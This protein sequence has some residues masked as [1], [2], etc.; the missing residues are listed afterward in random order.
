MERLPSR[1]APGLSAPTYGINCAPFLALCVL[2]FIASDDCGELASVRLAL[3]RQTYVDDIFCVG[4]DSEEQALELQSNL[5][6]VLSKS[7]LE[8]KKWATNIR[9]KKYGRH[10]GIVPKC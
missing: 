3:E 8:L 1:K 7:G 9:R 10:V 6:T 2:R 4:T 5:T